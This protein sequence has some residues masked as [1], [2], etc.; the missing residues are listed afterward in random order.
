MSPKPDA[1]IFDMD[2]TLWDALSTYLH[3]WNFTLDSLHLENISLSQLKSV[4]GMEKEKA[5][6]LLFPKLSQQEK[7]TIAQLVEQ[8]QNIILPK[9]GAPLYD[10]VALGLQQLSEMYKL[11]IVSN[12]EADTI[13]QMMKFTQIENYIIDEMAHGVNLK[14]K[15]HNIKLLMEK[16][17][18]KNPIYVGDTEG[19]KL[20][21]SLVP[22]PF[23]FVSYG[24]G[25]A[26]GEYNFKTFKDLSIYFLEQ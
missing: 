5:F 7:D 10:G 20:Q 9:M 22:L 26:V 1:L 18:L 25:E 4:M 14:P 6:K 2:G 17:K 24:Y 23:A 11:F 12:C 8:N 19:D 13:K 16:Y 21:A 3:I 15:H